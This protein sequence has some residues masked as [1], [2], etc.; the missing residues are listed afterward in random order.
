[1]NTEVAVAL[2]GVFGGVFAA[3]VSAILPE[4]FKRLRKAK[5]QINMLNFR[6]GSNAGNTL[7]KKPPPIGSF[8]L[9]NETKEEN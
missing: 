1:M 3:V 4:L 5:A 9:R 8:V 2:I 6:R 7:V